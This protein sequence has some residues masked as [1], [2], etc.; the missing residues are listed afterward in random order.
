MARWPKYYKRRLFSCVTFTSDD[1]FK[2]DLQAKTEKSYCVLENKS[3]STIY[4]NRDGL[5][6]VFLV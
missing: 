2:K 4:H 1:F 6:Q 5:H 3:T